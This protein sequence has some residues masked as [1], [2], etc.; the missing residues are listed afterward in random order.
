M[1][2]PR[3]APEEHA[4]F[5]RMYETEPVELIAAA[6]GRTADNI[7][8]RAS[9]FG[10]RRSSAYMAGLADTR[11]ANL[12]LGQVRPHPIGTERTNKGRMERKVAPNCWKPVHVIT[13]EAEHGPV[14]DGY[15][16]AFK[17]GKSPLLENLECISAAE[18]MNRNS[19]HNYPA[20]IPQ[21]AMLR[22]VLTRKIRELSNG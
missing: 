2:K 8:R 4:L 22:G 11:E 14:P 9:R 7:H 20:P 19:V 13:W 10:M 15:V 18:L 16:I 5:V 12:R 6:L 21:L 3:W 1:K 17:S